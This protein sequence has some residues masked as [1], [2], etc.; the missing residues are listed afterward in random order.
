MKLLARLPRRP[1][2]N[3]DRYFC[4][5]L[6]EKIGRSPVQTELYQIGGLVLA[7]RYVKEWSG[8][9]QLTVPGSIYT[10]L[11]TGKRE[12][13]RG[14]ISLKYVSLFITDANV[15][16][17]LY[18][19]NFDILPCNPLVD[20]LPCNPLVPSYYSPRIPPVLPPTVLSPAL[21]S[22][23][24]DFVFPENTEGVQGR[25]LV[26]TREYKRHES[27]NRPCLS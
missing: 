24:P 18:S 15:L 13:M 16:W 21:Y 8:L 17:R 14:V 6:R 22:V 2:P 19:C 27:T 20:I 12:Y 4:F 26:D 3:F 10:L 23:L 9:P 1:D 25:V 5:S 11:D 7:R